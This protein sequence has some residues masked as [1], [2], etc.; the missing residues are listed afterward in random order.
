VLVVATF[1]LRKGAFEKGKKEKG[2]GGRFGDGWGSRA[3]PSTSEA[4]WRRRFEAQIYSSH[5]ETWGVMKPHGRVD[6]LVERDLFLSGS[7]QR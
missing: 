1:T 7:R 5:G 3:G 6:L 4:H 2:Q